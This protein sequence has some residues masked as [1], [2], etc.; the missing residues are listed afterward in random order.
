MNKAI[1]ERQF[2]PLPET[3]FIRMHHLLYL[4]G[5]IS[6]TMLYAGIAKGDFPP[7]KKLTARTSVW[8]V[9]DIRALLAKV[10][11]NANA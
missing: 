4:L 9:E 5:G 8:S 3:G 1:K 10:N 6:K 7:P 11:G 2:P